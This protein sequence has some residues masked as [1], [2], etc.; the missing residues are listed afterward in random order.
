MRKFLYIL[1]TI[2]YVFAIF[3][4]IKVIVFAVNTIGKD[5]EVPDCAEECV[6]INPSTNSFL[7]GLNFK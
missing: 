2:I 1:P 4:A 3:L 6:R 7:N 5:V